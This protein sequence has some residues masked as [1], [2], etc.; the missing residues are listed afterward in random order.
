LWNENSHKVLEVPI[1]NITKNASVDQYSFV[2]GATNEQWC[3]TKVASDAL[4]TVYTLKN[5]HSGKCLNDEN[6]IIGNHNPVDQ[7][8]CNGTP[9]EEWLLIPG[10]TL[11]STTGGAYFTPYIQANGFWVLE[12]SHASLA[13]GGTVDLYQ[14]VP[15]ATNELWC[16]VSC[17]G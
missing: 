17:L 7:Y 16:T 8:T 1:A 9:S 15:G 11:G 2:S 3:A 13:N 10:A 4:G 12:V 6:G 14:L 5:Q